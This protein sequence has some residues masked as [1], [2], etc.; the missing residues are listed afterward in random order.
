[1]YI[2]FIKYDNV[3]LIAK[4]ISNISV[5]KF[6]DNSVGRVH[7]QCRRPWLDSWV[8]KI[9]GEGIG[10]PLQYSWVSLVAQMAKNPSAIRETWVQLLGWEDP[11]EKW[12]LPI[13]VFW[14]GEFYRLYSPWSRKESDMTELISFS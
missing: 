6:P 2:I 11:L 1:M 8:G 7:L 3:F 9:T 10:H 5:G 14:P 4:L 12:Y 13:P